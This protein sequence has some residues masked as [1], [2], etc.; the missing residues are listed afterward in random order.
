MKKINIRTIAMFAAV[1]II[2]FLGCKKND[3]LAKADSEYEYLPQDVK[4]SCTVTETDFN[5][6]F[7]SGK[8]TENGLVEPANSVTFPH[9]NNCD[10]YKWSEQMF[11]WIT[12][13]ASGGAYKSGGTVMESPVFYNVSAADKNGNRVLTPHAPNTIMS[14]VGNIVQTGPNRLPIIVDKDGRTFEVESQKEH[15][16]VKN[17]ENKSVE[18]GSIV[19]NANGLHSFIDTKGKLISSPKAIIDSKVHPENILQEFKQGNKAVFLDSKGHIVDTEQGQ[20]GSSGALV[21][22][23]KS[24]VYY[25]TMVND[26][27]A[28]FLTGVKDK[29]LNGNQFPTTAAARDSILAYAKANG[30]AT[31]P[32]P[33]AL[34]M[35]LKTSWVEAKDLPNADSYITIKAKVPVYDKSNPKLWVLTNKSTTTTLALVGAHVVGSVAGHPEM[36]WATFEHQ[37]NSPNTAYSYRDVNDK[38]KQVKADSGTDWLFNVNADDTTKNT[39]R[40]TVKNNTI[41]I[42]SLH[43]ELIYKPDVKRIMA[44]GVASDT[45]P[46]GEDKTPADS[47]SE[48]I[49]INNAIRKMLV[50]NDIR[51]NYLLIGATWTFGGA[52]PDGSSYPYGG[53]PGAA[54]GTGRLA[55]S[56]METFFQS[57][58]SNAVPSKTDHKAVTSC[59]YCHGYSLTPGGLSHVFDSIVA[60]PT[61]KRNLLK[62][63]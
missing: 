47:N 62:I 1:L 22:V 54:I 50:G 5:S 48:I 29:K 46:N 42:D 4:Q 31:P 53:T 24:L 51:K 57:Q 45:I 60:L 39:Q 61:N 35:E 49:S 38:I 26:V 8:A 37:K 16:A 55:N 19:S 17:A 28:Y 2:L 11:L 43:P 58:S 18:V 15:E 10:F 36:I 56:T 14:A 44:W 7:K 40:M 34:A 20:A 13:P 59:F 12:S 9:N 21:A 23:N 32:D 30:L 25:I 27:Y 52:Q 3:I 6:W 63:K 41:I 33:D